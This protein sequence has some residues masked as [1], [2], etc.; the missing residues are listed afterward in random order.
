MLSSRLPIFQIE[1]HVPGIY[2]PLP[3]VSSDDS[4]VD[5]VA[6]FLRIC[7]GRLSFSHLMAFLLRHCV[8]TQN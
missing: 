1:T 2:K 3:L 6:I 7:F 5:A 4:L 8:Y